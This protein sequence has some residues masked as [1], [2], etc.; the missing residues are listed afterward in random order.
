VIYFAV[1]SGVS[2][3]LLSPLNG[4]FQAE[5]YGEGRLGTLSGVTVVVTSVAGAAGSWLGGVSVRSRAGSR[6]CWW[7]LSFFNRRR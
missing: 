6:Q 5:V 4:L 7:V 3:G 2:L 1:A